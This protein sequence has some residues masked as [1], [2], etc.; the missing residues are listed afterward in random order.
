MI[1]SLKYLLVLITI[2]NF[3]CMDYNSNIL[4][5]SDLLFSNSYRLKVPSY[6][7]FDTTYHVYH[8]RGD[9]N[10]FTG[11]TDTMN[12]MPVFRWDSIGISL[13]TVAIFDSLPVVNNNKLRNVKNIIWQWNSGMEFGKEGYVQYSDGRNV[14]NGKVN[15]MNKP[16]SLKG[17]S[18]YWAVWG[19]TA[20]GSEIMVSTRK[21]KF[22]VPE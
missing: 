10:Y 12:G 18:Y 20:D 14:F 16:L 15:Y 8:V 22:L 5:N 1:R 11:N 13:L 2:L 17:G 19:W 6:S 9:T 21:M 3:S 4:N 7:Y